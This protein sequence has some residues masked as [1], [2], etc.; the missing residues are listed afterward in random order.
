MVSSSSPLLLL[1]LLLLAVAA[2]TAEPQTLLVR[3]P[4]P[5]NEV[6]GSLSALVDPSDLRPLSDGSYHV[7]LPAPLLDMLSSAEY[8]VLDKSGPLRQKLARA[9][10]ALPVGYLDLEGIWDRLSTLVRS[11]PDILAFV[12]LTSYGPGRTFEGR[13]MPMVKLSD[14]VGINE[15]EPNILVLASHHAREIVNPHIVLDLLE[16]LLDGYARN[17]TRLRKLV[18]DNEI[19]LSP[20]WNPDG[21]YHV[22]EVDNMWRKNRKPQ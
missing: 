9:D 13:E 18:E 3:L 17:D 12:N 22:W 4:N 2:T 8:E 15:D 7:F 11:H 10:D 19:F 20:L 16:R 6:L 5:T 21:Y 1:S 14:N